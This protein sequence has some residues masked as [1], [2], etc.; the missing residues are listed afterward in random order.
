MATVTIY[1]KPGCHLCE[2]VTQTVEAVRRTHP[3]ELMIRDILDSPAD[4]ARYRHLI[5]VV[6]VDGAEI[7]R[8]RLSADDLVAALHRDG[9]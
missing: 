6:A 8:Y 5:P 2:S 7:A 4:F 9:A 3:F 1:V